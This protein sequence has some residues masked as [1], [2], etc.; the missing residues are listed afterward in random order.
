MSSFNV[1][2]KESRI[3]FI[4]TL[5]RPKEKEKHSAVGTKKRRKQKSDDKDVLIKN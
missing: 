4:P 1:S 3:P 5:V 2:K